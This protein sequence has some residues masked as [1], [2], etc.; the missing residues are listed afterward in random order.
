MASQKFLVTIAAVSAA[1]FGAEQEHKYHQQIGTMASLKR[2]WC[3]TGGALEQE[4][5]RLEQRLS[6][7]YNFVNVHLL[8]KGRG[9]SYIIETRIPRSITPV[10]GHSLGELPHQ[11]LVK[12]S[13]KLG[14]VPA[15]MIDLAQCALEFLTIHMKRMGATMDGKELYITR[16]ERVLTHDPPVTIWVLKSITRQEGSVVSIWNRLPVLNVN[17]I[18]QMAFHKQVIGH[19]MFERFLMVLEES[20]DLAAVSVPGEFLDPYGTVAKMKALINEIYQMIVD[21]HKLK[22]KW[23]LS[24]LI[25]TPSCMEKAQEELDRVARDSRVQEEDLDELVYLKAKETFRL[26]PPLPLLLPRES[27]QKCTFQGE[28]ENPKG[29]TVYCQSLGN[30][31]GSQPMGIPE[32]FK[33]E[34]FLESSIVIVGTIY[35]PWWSSPL[36]VYSRL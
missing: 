3:L 13:K 2:G 6:M 12:L 23:A 27:T 18:A 28:Y 36:L 24:S 11:S 17:N 5:N 26:H 15:L 20:L 1:V 22:R 31:A 29:L 8:V 19:P 33:P 30:R 7:E 25:N 16:G 32:Q 21:E 4:E 10:F 14:V 34:G 9:F 35:R